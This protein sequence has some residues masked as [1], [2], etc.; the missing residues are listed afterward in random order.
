[1]PHNMFQ[2]FVFNPVYSGY[3]KLVHDNS[4]VAFYSGQFPVVHPT[5]LTTLTDTFGLPGSSG[6]ANFANVSAAF[7]GGGN[8]TQ[9]IFHTGANT[10]PLLTATAPLP[11]FSGASYIGWMQCTF[12]TVFNNFWQ[13]TINALGTSIFENGS[14]SNLTFNGNGTAYKFSSHPGVHMIA[15]VLQPPA[16]HSSTTTTGTL[17]IDA[18]VVS[19]LTNCAVPGT[20]ISGDLYTSIV[21]PQTAFAFV[22]AALSMHSVAFTQAQITTFFNT[23]LGT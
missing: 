18:N 23:G 13:L 6:Q 2:N 1:M 9:A 16:T 5:G 19:T 20:T 11:A 4:P 12:P 3:E 7:M 14:S 15:I 17:Y 22:A 8:F 21:Q 10:N